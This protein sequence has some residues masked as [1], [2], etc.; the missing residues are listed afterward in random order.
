MGSKFIN[1]IKYFFERLFSRE[2]KPLLMLSIISI[3]I[4][5]LEMI[6]YIALISGAS[7]V[8]IAI[9]LLYTYFSYFFYR[10]MVRFIQYLLKRV[11]VLHYHTDDFNYLDNDINAKIRKYNNSIY[12]QERDRY[13][14][15][16]IYNITLALFLFIV[17]HFIV[18]TETIIKIALLLVIIVPFFLFLKEPYEIITI[19]VPDQDLID[20][21]KKDFYEQFLD[22]IFKE[23]QITSL[24]DLPGQDT[25]EPDINY[26]EE[27]YYAQEQ[28]YNNQV[29]QEQQQVQYSNPMPQQQPMVAA[30]QATDPNQ[31]NPFDDVS[32]EINPNQI[33][34]QWWQQ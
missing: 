2:G 25:P 8:N 20:M 27:Q 12:I 5:V 34:K 30:S 7:K 3:V 4:A 29:Y 32:K 21:T 31:Y 18:N 16:I 22:M 28:A 9:L 6:L 23:K 17:L 15:S 1:D 10:L 26:T 14:A 19:D 13:E 11:N 24:V 33:P